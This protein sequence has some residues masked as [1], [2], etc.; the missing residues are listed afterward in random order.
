[1]RQGNR[2]D[3]IELDDNFT[4][5]RSWVQGGMEVYA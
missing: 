1:V 2:A 3:L 4:V 5:V